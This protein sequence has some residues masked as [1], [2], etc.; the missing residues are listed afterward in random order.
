MSCNCDVTQAA[1]YVR[2]ECY[3]QPGHIH[4][5]V[6]FCLGAHKLHVVTGRWQ[7]SSRADGRV[8]RWCVP[9]CSAS[10]VDGT[11]CGWI[12]DGRHVVFD[13]ARYQSL[14]HRFAGLFAGC[15]DSMHAFM[16]QDNQAGKAHVCSLY[17]RYCKCILS[18]LVQRFTIACQYSPKEMTR[19]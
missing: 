8:C 17:T 15:G 6:L 7:G 13:C 12:E 14:R 2:C 19:I 9:H 4:S 16:G 11:S 3:V 18:Q 5:L 10:G 1:K